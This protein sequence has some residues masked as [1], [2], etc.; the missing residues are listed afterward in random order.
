MNFCWA[1]LNVANLENSLKFYHNILGLPISSRH[2]GNGIELAMLGEDHKPQIELLCSSKVTDIQS[3]FGISI[4]IEVDSLE[5]TIEY[6]NSKGISIIRG[7]IS[8]NAYTS[9]IFVSDPDGYEVQL[10]ENK[11]V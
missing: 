9:F 3:G 1:T 11:Q 10:V 4:G 7:P 6:L 8:P 2:G 5:E